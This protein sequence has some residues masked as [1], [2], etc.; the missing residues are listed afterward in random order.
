MRFSLFALVAVLTPINAFVPISTQSGQT[1]SKKTFI[2]DKNQKMLQESW[3]ST[4]YSFDTSLKMAFKS[5]Q[6]SNMFD[7]PT[8][9]V[10]ERD[11]CGVGFI[12]NTISGEYGSHKVLSEAL[13]ALGC[14]EHRGACGGDS[15]SGDGAGIMTQIPWKLF[16]DYRSESCPEP[17]VGM[18]FLP[19]D[20]ERQNSVKQVIQEVCEAN[21]LGF[22][23][24]REVPV[25]PSVLGPMA[26]DAMPSIW[27]FFVKAPKRLDGDDDV[28]D[29][30][31]RT[32]YLVRRR[33]NVVLK[34]KGL[35]WDD[36]ASDVYMPSF[37]SRTI[38]YKGMVQ[39]CVLPEFYKDLTDEDF[40]T[41][42]AIYHR[43][44]STNTNPKWP[45]AQP[46]RVVGH[47]G[48][49]NTLLG[50][51]NWVKAREASKSIRE[52]CDVNDLVDYEATDNILMKC[53]TQDIPNILEPLVDLGRS[54]S[55]NLDAVFD[56]MTKSRHRAPCALMALVPTA[57]EN[58]PDLKNNPEIVDFYKFHGGLLEA[59]DGPALLVY[60]DG[61]SI[62][63]SLDRNGLRPARYS[64]TKDGTVY[65][66]SE[67]GVIP[68]LEESNIVEK[69][70]LGPGQMINV[71]LATGEFKD[72]IKIKSEIA[73]RHP[74]G[75]WMD[76]Q[77]KDIN[78]MP[79]STERIY[80][81]ATATFAQASF[82]WG[83]EDIG[84]Q[85]ADMAGSGKETT[86][87]MGDDAPISVLSERPQPLYN[88]LKQRFAQV[89]NPPID[90]LREGIVMSLAM[91]LG[92]KESIYEVSEKGARLVHL[93][94]PL[95]NDNEMNAIKDLA[96]SDN[97]G[98]DQATLSTR[99]PLTDG[100]DAIKGKIEELCNAAVE[101]VKSG[102]EVLILTDLAADQSV[103]DETTYIPP[104][105]AVGAVHHRLIEEGLRMDAGII[106]QT[107]QA[108]STHHF[109]CLV[110]YGANAVHPY[111][112]L[113]TVKQ[114]HQSERVQ[115]TMEAGKI[116]KTTLDQAQANFR[117]SVEDGLRKILSK[118]GISLLT[119]YAGAQIFEA[120][121]LG[122]EV[123]NTSLKGTTSRIGGMNLADVAQ[124]TVMMRP[125]VADAKL[126]LINYGYYKPVPSKGEYHIN[127]SDLA[128][129]LHN[130][131]GLD[132]KV[133]AA[134]TR[135]TAENDGVKPSSVANY[136]IFKK[137]LETAPLA[138]IRD[139]LD[140]E[141]D[142][143]SIP[144][145]DVEPAS[146]IM[147]RFCTGA[148]S[149]GALSREAHETLAIAVNRIGGKS[150]SGEGGE[151]VVRGSPLGDVDEK[152][153]SPTFPHLAGLK[154]G[155]SANS[156]IHQVASGRFGVTPEFLVTAKQLEIKMAQGAKPGEGG[157]LPGPKVSEYIATLRAS[158]PGVTLISPPPHHDIYS[159]EDLAQLIHD[160]HAVNEKAGVSVK[161]VSSIGIG[162]VACG[163]AKAQADVI[164]I[165]G[166]DGGTGA[167]PLSSIKHAGCP[168]EFGLSEAHSAL[169]NNGLR[170]RVTIRVDGGVRTGRDVVIAG[171][172]GSEEFGFGTIAMIAEGCVMAR[173]CH[174]NTCPVGVTSQKE[175]L[176]KKFPGTPE[177]VVN[178]FE[179]VSEEI[180]ELMAHLGYSRFEDLIGRADLLKS[181]DSQAGRV[182]KTDGVNLDRFF[183]G[184]PDSAEDRSF[185]RAKI[186]GGI[187][188]P[189][190]EIVHIN[191]FSSDLDRKISQDESVK[192]VIAE[193][194]G[195]TVLR[196]DIKNTDRSTG[197]MLS[198]DIAR[199]HGNNGFKGKINVQLEGS[200]GQSFG[201][202]VLPGL[203]IRLAGEANDYVGKGMHGGEIV[204]VPADDAGFVASESSIV[205]NACLYG[206]TG[207][208]FHANGRA[209]E[210]FCVRNSGAFAVAEGAG[211][212]CCEYM[213]GGVVVML[214][215]VGRN[216][217]AG[218][219]GGVGYF[220]DSD[221]SF[222]ERVNGEIVS[223]Q[224][225]VSAAGEAQL[226]TL[227]ERHFEKTG[228]E[229]ADEILNNWESE[230]QKF[231]QIFPPS[232]A[233]ALTVNAEAEGEIET[234]R[235][236][237]SA[238][239]GD[240]CFLSVGGQLNEGQTAR[241]AD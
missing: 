150:N 33:F 36:T 24:W 129:L 186:E 75:E 71:D 97:G 199:A 231:W 214:G 22:I 104:L 37:S 138:N 116:A 237:A 78:T 102:V 57:Y 238:P 172:L 213:T 156:F 177:H 56:L 5:D 146:S 169:L 28:R 204:V 114:W 241:C 55:A 63:A 61:K 80:D 233:G 209:G 185:L 127:S 62:G 161:L 166:G 84:M 17:G 83:L 119:S 16:D 112:A 1:V 52:E 239:S 201:A 30:F 206:A 217:G 189:K 171:M 195:E 39:S 193:N 88:Y 8:P 148:M 147:T 225:L 151:D 64:I 163:V 43:R 178:F 42:F 120:I 230:K 141:S 126:K 76:K 7:G 173:V 99:F 103:L 2:T 157:Q 38:V 51:V 23:G 32:L 41:K 240:L 205:G 235:V 175:Q 184:I 200:A 108:W 168:W 140:F 123:V 229:K 131:I 26:R 202:F 25:D 154:N 219:T 221:D 89:T 27:Q 149:L 198:G 220:Y 15:I 134:T 226:K 46:M 93:E 65:M 136:E 218:M 81:D 110:G 167:S 176:R 101:Q 121:G 223:M 158:K 132:K 139:L 208:D 106:V 12:A 74:Y 117:K 3:S 174:L 197:A 210:R 160:L 69:G 77:R 113:E 190:E 20:E 109:A 21:E 194:E 222:S 228:S 40:T 203:N 155:D 10:K 91:T 153:R 135:D 87:S 207:G 234:T 14:M 9:L 90:P 236:S 124:E 159:I 215:T 183:S 144:I 212:H 152:G 95:L 29:G 54:D 58:S 98:F 31:E 115:K 191:G 118:I 164:Q 82:G 142:R 34:Q 4:G 11:A 165:S 68:G 143:Q 182:A 111:L 73:S 49:I 70:R 232:E 92:K 47:N 45:L 170:D 137:S 130:A 100:P 105:V 59:W 67:T 48:E 125:E 128:K 107:G 79:F 60:S 145:E 187:E 96:K 196:F 94:S 133:S 13:H 180:R 85:I 35:Q 66:M 192:K 53:D 18:I 211:D 181:S 86:Y 188:V 122:E 44:F 216:V 19:P 50:N 179:F 224:R 72:N 6:P 162:T 227:I